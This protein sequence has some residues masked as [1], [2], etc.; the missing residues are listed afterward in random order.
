MLQ[1]AVHAPIADET[2]GLRWQVKDLRAVVTEFGI[3]TEISYQGRRF[4]I[5]NSQLFQLLSL[6][7]FPGQ[8]LAVL[9]SQVGGKIF[10]VEAAL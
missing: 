4:G 2:E 5:F 10:G 3:R 6:P 8:F 1:G 9:C 7:G